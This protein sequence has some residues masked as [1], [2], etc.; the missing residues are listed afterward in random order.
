MAL[1]N[2]TLHEESSVTHRGRWR[3]AEPRQTGKAAP[4][5]WATGL[6]QHIPSP[7]LSCMQA[8]S[9]V[10]LREQFHYIFMNRH[11]PAEQW[12]SRPHYSVSN[13]LLLLQGR[14]IQSPALE[15]STTAF[16]AARVGHMH[17]DRELVSRSR[18]LYIDGLAQLRQALR[19][20]SSRLSDETLAACMALSFYEISEGPPGSRNTYGTHSK[21]A[22]SLLKMRGPE[23]CG[24]SALGHA[25]FLALRIQTVGFILLDGRLT[26]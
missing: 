9:H 15:M 8:P 6:P 3:K 23:A 16:F 11:M 12:D 1:P 14:T 25:L 17:G 5:A 7:S 10:V 24:E 20:P 18:S 4:V 21:G 19:D 22:V 13:W 26:C 2:T